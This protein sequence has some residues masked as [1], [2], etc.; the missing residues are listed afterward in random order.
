[1]NSSATTAGDL[2]LVARDLKRFRDKRYQLQ[3]KAA[4]EAEECQRAKREV[5]RREEEHHRA[6]DEEGL[7]S[8]E[9]GQ[10]HREERGRRRNVNVHWQSGRIKNT[11]TL[12]WMPKTTFWTTSSLRE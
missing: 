2:D 9:R 8:A 12:K 5:A 7:R 11:D 1:M 3:Q 10:Q 6:E 4:K